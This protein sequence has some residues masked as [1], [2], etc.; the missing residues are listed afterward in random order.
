[1]KFEIWQAIVLV[2][3]VL[4]I[5]VTL[6]IARR[7]DAD[8]FQKSAQ[9]VIVWVVPFIAAIGLWLFHRNNDNTYPGSRPVGGGPSD[10]IGTHS[11]GGD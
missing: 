10:S 4:N 7:D 3:L 9:I 5:L 11:G 1:M 8:T 2:A 6:V